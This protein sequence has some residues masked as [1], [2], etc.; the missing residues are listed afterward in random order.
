MADLNYN[1][2]VVAPLS[3]EGKSRV[4]FSIF[5]TGD[6]F[7]TTLKINNAPFASIFAADGAYS[8][9]NAGITKTTGNNTADRRY[10]GASFGVGAEIAF[11]FTAA[12]F[13]NLAI[14][15]TLGTEFGFELAILAIVKIAANSFEARVVH[16]HGYGQ[17]I[18]IGNNDVLTIRQ[19]ASAFE[20]RK[21]GV[22]FGTVNRV[23]LYDAT[24]DSLG[25]LSQT[26][27]IAAGMPVTFTAS[28]ATVAQNGTLTAVYDTDATNNLTGGGSDAASDAAFVNLVTD[29]TKS[30]SVPAFAITSPVGTAGVSGG[31]SISLTANG[32]AN[33]SDGAGGTFSPSAANRQT[34]SYTPAGAGTT[35]NVTAAAI[36][37]LSATAVKALTVYPQLVAQANGTIFPLNE[38]LRISRSGT[39][40][41]A[42]SGGSGSVRWNASAGIIGASS[43]LYLAPLSASSA[44]VTV[45]DLNTGQQLNFNIIIEAN[46]DICIKERPETVLDEAVGCCDSV[47]EC[48]ETTNFELPTAT[49]S[50]ADYGINSASPDWSAKHLMDA[51]GDYGKITS[52]AANAGAMAQKIPAGGSGRYTQIIHAS[53]ISAGVNVI[54]AG[55]SGAFAAGIFADV[56]FGI[57]VDDD[58]FVAVWENGVRMGIFGLARAGHSLTVGVEKGAVV[59]YKDAAKVFTSAKNICGDLF[60]NITAGAPNIVFAG[61]AEAVWTIVTTGTAEEVGSITANGGYAAPQDTEIGE[62]V[63]QAAVGDVSHQRTIALVN[64]IPQYQDVR[65]F[66]TGEVV[67]CYL[68]ASPVPVGK[69]PRIARSGALDRNTNLKAIAVGE[70]EDGYEFKDNNN[71]KEVGSDRGTLKVTRSKP[72]VMLT[73]TMLGHRNVKRLTTAFAQLSAKRING[74]TQV[75]AG[76]SYCECPMTVVLIRPSHS[77][78]DKYDA[79]VIH[80]AVAMA[81]I[82]LTFK[83][84]ELLKHKVEVVGFADTRRPRDERLYSFYFNLDCDESLDACG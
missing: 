64:P 47:L 6:R 33:W 32:P 70:V 37:N 27:V 62:V 84:E 29:E 22:I 17:T 14:G 53:M 35:R 3:I 55:L 30:V 83:T 80:R 34:V 21:N 54:A 16:A 59:F 38:P 51:F 42:V 69:K 52:R 46:M 48:G 31:N 58:G 4:R 66:V 63:V 67:E 15:A 23:V 43:G 25:T 1:P 68:L 8:V 77:C 60:V 12:D 39:T 56:E 44:V 24:P 65:E 71:W 75:S 5:N 72:K 82:D 57:G 50:S 73:F 10:S 79:L 9:T 20:F 78:A 13:T 76:S 2:C 18:A 26:T 36:C 81:D 74:A 19:T 11:R 40:V 45:T 7:D 41:F 49:Y 28:A 61:A